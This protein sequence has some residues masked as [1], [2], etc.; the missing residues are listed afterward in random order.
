M[1]S[2]IIIYIFFF[3]TLPVFLSAHN[4]IKGKVTDKGDSNAPIAGASIYF[5]AQ[6]T[7]T[8]SDSLGNFVIDVHANL[9]FTMIVSMLGYR[10]DKIG[11]AHV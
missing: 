3:C 10:S 8:Q 6:N 4:L 1:K 11:R 5:P 2:K 7:G 9:P